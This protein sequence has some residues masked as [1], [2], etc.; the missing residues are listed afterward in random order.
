MEDHKMCSFDIVTF[1]KSYQTGTFIGAAP[2]IFL[3]YDHLITLDREVELF[4][5]SKLTSSAS[6]LYVATRYIALVYNVLS[7]LMM[8]P[9]ISA[10]RLHLRHTGEGP[11][12]CGLRPISSSSSIFRDAGLRTIQE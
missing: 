11:F 7:I 1:Y 2:R 6:I 10:Q 5:T 3:L 8:F 4:R 12:G 9:A